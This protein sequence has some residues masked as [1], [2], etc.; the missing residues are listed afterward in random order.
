MPTAL[1]H[2][3]GEQAHSKPLR[4]TA[5]RRATRAIRARSPSST[6]AA[7]VRPSPHRSAAVHR[8]VLM[9][10]V[11]HESQAR[12]RAVQKLRPNSL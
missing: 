6:T 9:A 12:L 11:Q 4:R 3:G 10:R 7:L 1:D 5:L 8:R 2:I